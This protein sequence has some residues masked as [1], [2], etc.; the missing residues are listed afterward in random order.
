MSARRPRHIMSGMTKTS[1][2]RLAARLILA[3]LGA[4]AVTTLEAQQPPVPAP[5]GVPGGGPETGLNQRPP[6]GAGQQPAFA[7][8]TRAPEQKLERR[9][10]TV[11]TVAEGL[12]NPWGLAFLPDGRMLVT[13]RPGRLRVRRAPTA[14]C[15]SRSPACRR[16]T[17]R[18]QGG[19]LDVALDPTFAQ[20]RLIYW[21][22]AEPRRRRHEQHRGGARHASSTAPRRAL[23]DVQVIF[24]QAPSLDSHAALRQP[25]GVRPATARCSSRMGERSITAGRMQAQKLDSLLGKIVRINPDGSIPKDNP[26][27]G[28]AGVRPEIWSLRPSQHP[29]G[30]AAPDAP[31]SCGRSSTA[32]A[33]AT[34]STSRARARTTAGRPSP[35]A[36]STRAGRSPAASSSR[37]AWSS[38]STTGIRSSR[39]AAWLFYTGD[40]VPGVEGQ[41]VRR[42][43]RQHEPRAADART[44]RRS[45]ARSGCCRTSS[46]SASASA[47]C[48]RVPT[49]RSTC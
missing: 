29:V 18:G 14:R 6:N 25:A 42:R 40:A 48:A 31:A 22:Y 1:L 19:L 26:F 13:E 27:V 8:Q 12:Q 35:T 36:S 47:T 15:R 16:S 4:V 49:A 32:P 46:R 33:A 39:R 11:V 45:S 24:H 17:R 2:S 44:A 37:R 28:K 21:S 43:P 23:D 38:R 30:D 5:R 34:S 20:N 3:A 7:G 41:P 9:R 10:S